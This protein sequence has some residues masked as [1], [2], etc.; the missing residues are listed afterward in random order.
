M[1]HT[2]PI[3]FLIFFNSQF[4]RSFQF[5]DHIVVLDNIR[6]HRSEGGQ[7][8]IKLTLR[9]KLRKINY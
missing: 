4:I 2:L 1:Y 6:H 7:K 5:W 9:K 8:L 3:H